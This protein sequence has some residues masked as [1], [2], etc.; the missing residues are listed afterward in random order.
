MTR[1][2]LLLVPVTRTA[3]IL[4]IPGIDTRVSSRLVSQGNGMFDSKTVP[5]SHALVPDAAGSRWRKLMSSRI[6]RIIL[7]ASDVWNSWGKSGPR[8]WRGTVHGMGQRVLS[9]IDAKETFFRKLNLDHRFTAEVPP[10]GLQILVPKDLKR[11]SVLQYLDDCTSRAIPLHRLWFRVNAAFVPFTALLGLVPGPNIPLFWNLFRVYSHWNA[12]KAAERLQH[13]RT[14]DTQVQSHV[15]LD[16]AMEAVHSEKFLTGPV[17]D[18]MITTFHVPDLT[19]TILT[20]QRQEKR[21]PGNF[22]LEQ[23]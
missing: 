6:E 15:L 21:R 17:L 11:E 18:E 9:R 5:G 12:W 2:R 16:M 1:F 8:T 4:H 14:R 7:N 22:A 3:W 13:L 10:S 23:R 19:E 20:V